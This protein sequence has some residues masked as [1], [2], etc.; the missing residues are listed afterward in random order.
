[1][2]ITN[3]GNNE[4]ADATAEATQNDIIN[5]ITADAKQFDVRLTR[6]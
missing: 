3:T 1:M 6:Y 5:T 4:N 2:H